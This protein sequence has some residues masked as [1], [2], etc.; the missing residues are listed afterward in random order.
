MLINNNKPKTPFVINLGKQ[1]VIKEIPAMTFKANK[2]E[3][4][5]ITDSASDKTVV[6]T[7]TNGTKVTLWQG[8]D[9]DAI[10]QWTDTD[11]ENKIKDIYK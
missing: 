1:V 5:S 9:Y 4:D 7:L 6:A 3:I 8:S 10:G 2:I 11:V